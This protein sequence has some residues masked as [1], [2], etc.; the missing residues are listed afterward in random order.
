MTAA[1]SGMHGWTINTRKK[2]G[3]GRKLTGCAA[4]YSRRQNLNG[5]NA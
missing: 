1:K 4:N 5:N 3:E 2:L